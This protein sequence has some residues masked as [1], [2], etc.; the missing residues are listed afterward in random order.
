[1]QNANKRAK[2]FLV[3]ND[4]FQYFCLRETSQRQKGFFFLKYFVFD[5][6]CFYVDT[7]FKS[8]SLE[9]RYL[10]HRISQ[11]LNRKCCLIMHSPSRLFSFFIFHVQ[12]KIKC[13]Y[14]KFESTIWMIFF[15]GIT[16]EFRTSANRCGLDICKQ[17]GLD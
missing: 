13:K 2:I 11:F 15:N 3:K 12:H 14:K 10:Q 17:I 9:P 4:P 5:R 7:P 1:M 16:R 6:M 8:R